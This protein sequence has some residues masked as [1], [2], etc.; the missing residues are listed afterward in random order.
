MNNFQPVE[1]LFSALNPGHGLVG[2]AWPEKSQAKPSTALF[3][4]LT[5]F[6]KQ[7]TMTCA[8][9]SSEFCGRKKG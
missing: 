6:K 8:W 4:T 2:L 3:T 1:V 7:I 9:T 5:T